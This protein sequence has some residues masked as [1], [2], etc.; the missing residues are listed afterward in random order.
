[1]VLDA[2]RV[3]SQPYAWEAL[4]RVLRS[5]EIRIE[6]LGQTL[7]LISTASLEPEPIPLSVKV[8]L[9]GE[10]LLYYLLCQRDD[11]FDELFKVAADFEEEMDRSPANQLLYAKLIGQLA[12]QENL[13][14][15]DRGAVAR[16]IEHS[17]RIAGDSEKLSLHNRTLSDLLRP[18]PRPHLDIAD[19][20]A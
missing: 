2:Y 7:S 14:P 20:G 17:A 11:E 4:K 16:V 1:L 18:T 3:L 10:R 13:L 8:V 9:V 19:L 5:G 6:S 15:F 12:R